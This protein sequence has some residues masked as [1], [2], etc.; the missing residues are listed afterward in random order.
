M[1]HG[2]RW[3]VWL[4]H[5]AVALCYA[6]GYA[7]LRQVSWSH[8]V[9]FT[10][11]RLSV[12]LLV[13][14]RYWPALVIGEI[15]P[16]AYVSLSCL[17][18]FGWVWSSLMLVP[19][20]ALAMP[21][22]KACRDR[23][24]MIPA[25]GP[26]RMGAVLICTLVISGLWS[27]MNLAAL[28]VV[29]TPSN[30][31]PIDYG[32]AAAQYFIGNYL[33]ILTLVPLVL[34]VWEGRAKRAA[35]W[36]VTIE[37]ALRGRLA[38][39]SVAFVLPALALL[40]WIGLEASSVGS[41]QVAQM[42]MFL[43]VIWLALRH[44]WHGAAVGGAVASIAVV[45]TMP[46]LRD[47]ST[48]QAEV[49]VAFATTSMLLFGSRIAQLHQ[50]KGHGGEPAEKSLDLARRIQAQCEAQLR[51]TSLGIELISET[52][53][54]TEEMMFE[55][56]RQFRPQ[57]DSRELRRRTTVTREQLFQL[58]DGLNPVTLREQG[59]AAALRHGG[60]ARA[61]NSHRIGYWCRARGGVD[62]LSHPMQLAL[63]RLVCEVVTHLCAAH[64]VGD[65]TVHL[66]SGQ[67]A[68]RRWAVVRIDALFSADS[69]L[70][71]R[72]GPLLHRLAATGLGMDAIRDR[73]AL[74]EGTIKVH[75]TAHGECISMMVYDDEADS[76][77]QVVLVER[78]TPE[79]FSFS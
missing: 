49:F 41:R 70:L 37:N 78:T 43:P 34:M 15:G 40:V 75:T 79:I 35:S 30:Y 76:L 61:L 25:R 38:I 23:L 47:T 21:V 51:Q 22:V 42:L 16:L 58:A 17:E 54:A 7:L 9:L 13:P 59:L 67:H 18:S 63:H 2:I 65:L 12:L 62:Q 19:P 60:I 48:L 71:V 3:S 33:G 77:E 26:V 69:G 14:Y 27:L 44:G 5:G 68:G 6:L 46:E 20:I 11:Y 56:L 50:Q 28:S 55:R 64:S 31:P 8:W 73:A 66:R 10:G 57:V 1:S 72:G 24:S 4:R 53:H 39:E 36:R 29:K 45:V 32:V 74:Y 52:V